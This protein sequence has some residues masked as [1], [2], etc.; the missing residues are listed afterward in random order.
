MKAQIIDTVVLMALLGAFMYFTLARASSQ[1]GNPYDPYLNY[2][3]QQRQQ[4]ALEIQRRQL[5]IMEQ[6]QILLWTSPVQP[7]LIDPWYLELQ[8]EPLQ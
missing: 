8:A 5:Q 4:E 6:N 1:Y 2:Q 3:Q 7:Q